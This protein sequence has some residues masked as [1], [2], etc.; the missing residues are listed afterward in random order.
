MR[1]MYGHRADLP[2]YS[3][4]VFVPADGYPQSFFLSLFFS[5]DLFAAITTTQI[6]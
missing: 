2:M 3:A 6:A 1:L 5:C 4:P